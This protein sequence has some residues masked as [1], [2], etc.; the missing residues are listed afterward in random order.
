MSKALKK[1]R[2]KPEAEDKDPVRGSTELRTFGEEQLRSI[3]L[4]ITDVRR[5]SAASRRH[6]EHLSR[7]AAPNNGS[8]VQA[9]WMK[10]S[11]ASCDLRWVN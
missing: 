1:K 4:H 7:E 8:R 9:V 10:R 11:G 2:K 5:S 3:F 6:G